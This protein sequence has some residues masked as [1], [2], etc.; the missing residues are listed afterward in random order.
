MEKFEENLKDFKFSEIK[1]ESVWIL[2]SVIDV[3]IY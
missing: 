1:I 3:D 2:R